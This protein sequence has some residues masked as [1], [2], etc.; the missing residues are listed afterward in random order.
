MSAPASSAALR[1]AN[2]SQAVNESRFEPADSLDDFPTPPWATRALFECVLPQI[3]IHKSTVEAWS[4]WEPACNR[5]FMAEAISEYCGTVFC[6]D[7]HDYGYPKCRVGSFVGGESDFN[8]D[9]APSPGE[10]IDA[11]ITN[12]PFR[13]ADA[14]L[15]RALDEAP[16]VAF[17]LRTSWLEG[18]ARYNNTFRKTPPFAVGVFA[19]RVSIVKGCWDPSANRPTSYSWF[20]WLR[21]NYADPRLIWVPPGQA[22]RL[23]RFDDVRRFG[24]GAA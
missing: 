23:T 10:H 1:K 12:P 21:G 19:E 4:I 3:G 11:V 17:L 24:K 22:G 18:E 16:L 20:V 8:F 15:R 5:G 6:S 7:V 9:I 2:R 14:F 13:L